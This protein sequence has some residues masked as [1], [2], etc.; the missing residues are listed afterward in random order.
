M[1]VFSESNRAPKI[2]SFSLAPDQL[3]THVFSNCQVRLRRPLHL[4][5]AGYAIRHKL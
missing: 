4:L 1:R 2:N 5:L 3:K